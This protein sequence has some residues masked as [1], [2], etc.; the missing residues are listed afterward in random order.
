[1]AGQSPRTPPA[2]LITTTVDRVLQL[3]ATWPQWDGT[4][5]AVEVEGEEEPR[6]YTPHKAIRRVADHLLDHLAE[7]EARVAGRATHPDTWHGSLVTTPSDLAPFTEVDVDEAASRL[8]RIA[9]LWE[10]RLL[11]LSD[12][13]LDAPAGDEWTLRQVTE[14]V[15]ESVF[16]AESVGDLG[17]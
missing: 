6:L 11:A 13:Q 5:F 7:I 10:I 2:E 8:R 12:D 1:M 15:A 4:P 3:A 14:H 17:S 9:Q 16:Y